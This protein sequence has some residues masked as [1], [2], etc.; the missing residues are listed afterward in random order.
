MPSVSIS[1]WLKGLLDKKVDREDHTSFD[2]AIR[3]LAYEAGEHNQDT[4]ATT[5]RSSTGDHPTDPFDTLGQVVGRFGGI[6][7]KKALKQKMDIHR[8][9]GLYPDLTTIAI[10]PIGVFDSFKEFDGV[11]ELNIADSGVNPFTVTQPADLVLSHQEHRETSMSQV[12]SL[13]RLFLVDEDEAGNEEAQIAALQ[14]AVFQLYE[15]RGYIEGEP[16]LREEPPTLADLHETLSRLADEPEESGAVRDAASNL[17]KTLDELESSDVYGLLNESGRLAIEENEINLVQL[18][19]VTGGD[20]AKV[21]NSAAVLNAIREA[22][23]ISGPV[24][25]VLD[26]AHYYF[27]ENPFQEVLHQEFR[28]GRHHDIA[29]DYNTQ[30]FADT[31]SQGMEILNHNTDIVEVY[32]PYHLEE[33]P[34]TVEADLNLDLSEDHQEFLKMPPGKA[35][36]EYLQRTQDTGWDICAYNPQGR[37]EELLQKHSN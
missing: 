37:E 23:T 34:E 19:E 35:P 8:L 27:S 26:E 32:P 2:S 30:L 17:V 6:G 22:K 21:V 24:L 10:S 1:E 29:Y 7:S 3:A 12:V 13:L 18:S 16:S 9:M 31:Y 4:P 20:H 14:K 15:L 11:S 5:A 33:E 36:V 28:H 25:I